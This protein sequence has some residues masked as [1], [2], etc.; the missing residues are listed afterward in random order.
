MKL[1]IM[2]MD[3]EKKKDEI[4]LIEKYFNVNFNVYT[5]DEPELLQIDKRSITNYDETSNLMRC[6]NHLM[7]IKDLKQIRHSN[8]C[9]KIF[10]NMELCNRHEKHVIN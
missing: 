2:M 10:K 1:Y 7:Y 5:H 3:M 6:D 8:N 4:D 9:S